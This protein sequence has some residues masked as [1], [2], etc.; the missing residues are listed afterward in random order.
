[1][2]ETYFTDRLALRT[3]DAADANHVLQYFDRNR[4]FL[5]YWEPERDEAFYTVGY[6]KAL[7][8]K[9]QVEMDAGRML[10]LWIF[11]KDQPERT[12]GSLAFNNI[13]R[14][15]FL[16]CFLGYRLDAQEAGKG[17]MTEALRKGTE[18][19]FS[20]YG[21][22][23]IEANI[24]PRNAASLRAVTKAGFE[25]EGLARKYLKINGVWEDHIHMV[26]L[27]DRLE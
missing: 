23:R 5:E 13:V 6:H 16:S 27:N 9:E 25:S 10:R 17:Y 26:L 15:C 22:H 11:K 1:M 4:A 19:M 18:V 3:L 24:I 8:E 12:I 7:L 20:E 2:Q 21:L 14:G